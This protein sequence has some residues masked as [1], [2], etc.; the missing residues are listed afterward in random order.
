MTR[1]QQIFRHYQQAGALHSQI[2]VQEAIDSH[3]FITKA[4]YLFQVLSLN[5]LDDECLDPGQVEHISR[6]VESALRLLDENFRLSQYLIKT[7]GKLRVL[8]K[9]EAYLVLRQ[10][11]NFASHKAEAPELGYDQFVDWQV[12]DSA[13]ECHR[14]QTIRESQAL[15]V[16]S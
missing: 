11:V 12:C 16:L 13:L 6:Q 10:L 9:E 2:P 7:P 8:G 3:T 1:L 4:G 5:G 15:R 14:D